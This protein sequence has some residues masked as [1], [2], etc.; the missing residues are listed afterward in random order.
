[1][2]ALGRFDLYLNRAHRRECL[3]YADGGLVI[4]AGQ[5]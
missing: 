4:N 5:F 2:R 1:V 3:Q